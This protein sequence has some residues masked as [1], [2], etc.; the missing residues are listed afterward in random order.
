MSGKLMIEQQAH[1]QEESAAAGDEEKETSITSLSC[2]IP[3][4]GMPLRRSSAP[5]VEECNV[6]QA[7]GRQ[8]RCA[9]QHEDD[10]S[11]SQ[12]ADVPT[13]TS[14]H[15]KTRYTAP[16]KEAH[17]S[18]DL[19]RKDLMVFIQILLKYLDNNDRKL[20]VE[21][22]KAVAD[23]TKKNREGHPE[24]RLL[25]DSITNRLR[26]VV[27]DMHWSQLEN[28]MEH[29]RKKYVRAGTTR[30]SDSVHKFVAV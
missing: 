23:C 30:S 28:L 5:P 29:Y 16:P 13:S 12:S 25:V 10:C 22:K 20:R 9:P 11:Q 2:S 14:K 27:G 1:E 18:T 7:A 4:D 19:N 24:Y 8:T 21:V 26:L 3:Q 17:T 6:S 15:I